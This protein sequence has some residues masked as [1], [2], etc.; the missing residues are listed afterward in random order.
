MISAATQNPFHPYKVIMQRRSS[1]QLEPGWGP[2][3]TLFVLRFIPLI[4]AVVGVVLLVIQKE[5]FYLLIFGG[6]ALFEGFI[7]S[8]IKIPAALFMD[9][10]G[11]TLET[12]S[13]RGRR[14]DY[15]LWNDVN[16][17]RYRMIVGKNS[18]TLSYTAVLATGKKVNFLSF[19]NYHSK[20]H[21]I[22][23]INS[24]LHD[25]SKREVRKK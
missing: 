11:F 2:K 13:V 9:S 17:I 24:A 5:N 20:K 8:F 23:E 14:E 7:F 3:V 25:I 18:T 16:F 10:T 19:N 22:P 21:Q 6:F 12:F 1:L 15:Y 4:M